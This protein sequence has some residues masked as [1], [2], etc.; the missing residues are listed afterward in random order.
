[1][2]HSALKKKGIVTHATTWMNLEDVKLSDIRQSQKDKYCII[3]PIWGP[4]SQI[5][6]DR[7]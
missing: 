7:K 5:H 3:P 2:E 6:R 4:A 1:M